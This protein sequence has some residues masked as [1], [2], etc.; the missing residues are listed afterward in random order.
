MTAYQYAY[1]A[2]GPSG[3]RSATIIGAAIVA[4]C[5]LS[6]TL[7]MRELVGAP[8]ERATAAAATATAPTW[9]LQPRWWPGELRQIIRQAPT[10]P[11][12]DL[13]FANG[14]AQRVA[15]RQATARLAAIEPPAEIRS[16]RAA[17]VAHKAVA[18]AH[19]DGAPNLLNVSIARIDPLDDRPGQPD[20]GSHVL[21]FGE[22]RAGQRGFPEPRSAPPGG[23]FGNLY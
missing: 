15:A 12:N 3:A 5:V 10:A 14:Y 16:A 20:F 17:V 6:S 8:P 22:Q 9:D 19:S 1:T 21:A 4:V 13:T 7:V 18:V 11:E 2:G 23:L